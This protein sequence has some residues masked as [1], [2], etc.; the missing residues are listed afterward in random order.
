M[1]VTSLQLSADQDGDGLM[2]DEE[3]VLG[4]NPAVADTDQDGVP[5]FADMMP[6]DPSFKWPFPIAPLLGVQSNPTALP[7][8]ARWPAD[9]REPNASRERRHSTAHGVRGATAEAEVTAGARIG[10]GVAD[11]NLSAKIGR[12]GSKG[13][14]SG[15]QPGTVFLYV[16]NSANS[17]VSIRP[18][19][20]GL[21]PS[22]TCI[23]IISGAA[24]R[25]GTTLPC[26]A[27]GDGRSRDG[28]TP[29]TAAAAAASFSD[30]VGP[31]ERVVYALPSG[32]DDVL[33]NPSL[34]GAGVVVPGG[35]H[36]GD[37][38]SMV[39]TFDLSQALLR[40]QG[41]CDWTW[42]V[43][44]PNPT[45]RVDRAGGSADAVGLKGTDMPFTATVNASGVLIVARK[46][47]T[48]CGAANI[49]LTATGTNCKG[50]GRDRETAAGPA[51]GNGGSFKV[52]IV[53]LV[54]ALGTLG[55]SLL[56]NGNFSQAALP[57]AP[58]GTVAGW[59]TYT[60][61]GTFRASRTTA[62]SFTG[63]SDSA[64]TIGM[65]APSP[66][67]PQPA[68]SVPASAMIEGWAPGKFGLSQRVELHA[69]GTYELGSVVA[70]QGSE[71]GLFKQ[72]FSFLIIVDTPARIIGDIPLLP[73][74]PDP[75][76]GDAG[77]GGEGWRRFQGSM[78]ITAPTNITVYF[79]AWGAGFFFVTDVWL[80]LRA[81]GTP[82]SA[83]P[84][85]AFTLG[86]VVE[87]LNF[88]RQVTQT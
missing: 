37:P 21:Q 45:R 2:D 29:I 5:D 73:A 10:A 17:A 71:P 78:T 19:L 80:A 69:A 50:A 81:C 20:P 63:G 66:L 79:R 16:N 15:A 68:A 32:W 77:E 9:A 31:F 51:N 7:A 86:A 33:T 42:Q 13:S 4:T 46:S 54:T 72:T 84:N 55:P 18:T 82:A 6:L 43:G 41:R 60:W 34:A 48:S 14:G 44:D 22:T 85:E 23:T 47:A 88:T 8:G 57:S 67:P 53:V 27:G 59:G 83:D 74:S 64:N 40:P 75:A 87:P 65:T 36:P 52:P 25:R 28:S 58:P 35:A 12:S 26:S 49:T 39:A 30:V 11:S 61:Q 24:G 56:T 1:T 38:P 76:A 3:I 70:A 62:V